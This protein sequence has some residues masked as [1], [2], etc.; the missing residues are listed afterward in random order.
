M[1]GAVTISN[2]V[3][4]VALL[5]NSSA[6]GL[7]HESDT[8]KYQV[9]FTGT[10]QSDNSV[11]VTFTKLLKVFVHVRALPSFQKSS[12]SLIIGDN[13]KYSGGDIL[14][15]SAIAARIDA[16][17]EDGESISDKSKTSP[18]VTWTQDGGP[19]KS[20]TLTYRKGTS[21]HACFTWI[22]RILGISCRG[23]A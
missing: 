6:L 15:G 4:E 19:E 16:R 5:F 1:Q 22:I 9:K 10:A 23:G 14:A 20:V 18:I 3:D 7:F 13:K 2:P 11:R 12:L 17:D 21:P 8:I